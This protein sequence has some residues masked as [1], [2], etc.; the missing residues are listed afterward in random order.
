MVNIFD[1]APKYRFRSTDTVG[2]ADAESDMSIWRSA[3]STQGW[4]LCCSTAGI[5]GE[6]LLEELEPEKQLSLARL[7]AV[8]IT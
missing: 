5:I 2:V 6:S 1:M 3:L 8:R 7:L 4:L